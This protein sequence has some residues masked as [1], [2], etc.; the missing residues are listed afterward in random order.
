MAELSTLMSSCAFSI[1]LSDRSQLALGLAIE[2][3]TV[4]T[5]NIEYKTIH[6]TH[7]NM[8][9]LLLRARSLTVQSV[10][11]EGCGVVY[12]RAAYDHVI[13]WEPHVTTQL[14]H[15]IRVG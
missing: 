3:E 12:I 7:G 11:L 8:N 1:S 6:D 2:E 14:S 13:I 15:G 5:Y 10:L 4:S 9:T